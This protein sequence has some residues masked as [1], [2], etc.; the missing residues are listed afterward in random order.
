M[1]LLDL[2]ERCKGCLGAKKVMSTG[3]LYKLCPKCNGVGW[4]E[5]KPQTVEDKA[6]FEAIAANEKVKKRK[7]PKKRAKVDQT[8]EDEARI[9]KPVFNTDMNNLVNG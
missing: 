4:L 9:D 8:V 6:K 5:L 2:K 1:S 7:L 3:M